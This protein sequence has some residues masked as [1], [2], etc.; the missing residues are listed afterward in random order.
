MLTAARAG[1]AARDVFDDC[2]AG[3][4]DSDR[5]SRLEANAS[6]VETGANDY[7]AAGGTGTIHAIS[8]STYTP[9]AKSATTADFV[10]LYDQRLVQSKPGRVYYELLRDA[11][12]AGRCALCN[13]RPSSTLDHHLPKTDHP[14]FA[15]TPDNL[16]PACRECNATKLAS[17]TPTLN[18]YFDDLGT[19]PWLTVTIVPLSPP[20]FEFR[21][22]AQAC[23]GADLTARAKAHFELFGL[24]EMYAFQANR[25]LAGIRHRL[26]EL[27]A[28]HGPGAVA[29]HLQGEA[30]TWAA[31]EPNSWEAALYAAL[32]QSTW[33]C[34]GGFA[35]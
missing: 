30:D 5:K 23:W 19:G 8:A 16:V 27:L 24:A 35:R 17:L 6:K 10:W 22:D 9:L 1:F 12:R 13:V 31:G 11:N 3:I 14:I 28:D 29:T 21:I 18:P 33:F 25:Q 4:K 2:S 7:A 26:A 34:N 20:V 15:V 32:A